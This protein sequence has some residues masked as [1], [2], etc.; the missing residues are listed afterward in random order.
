MKTILLALSGLLIASGLCMAQ[1]APGTMSQNAQVILETQADGLYAA[2]SDIQAGTEIRIT[3]ETNGKAITATA[4]ERL[5]KSY[6]RVVSLSPDAA[7]QLGVSKDDWVKLTIASRPPPIQV[8]T[9]SASAEAAPVPGQPGGGNVTINNYYYIFD[10]DKLPELVNR[11]IDQNRSAASVI[12][13]VQVVPQETEEP[14]KPESGAS[15]LFW[16]PTPSQSQTTEEPKKPG[17]SGTNNRVA[18][19]QTDKIKIIGLPNPL[20]KKYYR[21]QVGAFLNNNMAKAIYQKLA[22]GG[23][24]P[25]IEYVKGRVYRVSVPKVAAADVLTQARRL[26]ALGFM[27]IWVREEK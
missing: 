6:G 22:N 27:E 24:K 2:H 3:N 7:K 14:K 17:N 10:P 4:I 26:G 12:Q 18:N 8:P 21:L 16:E 20:G 23:F 19:V 1:A 9:A 11:T 25:E 13:Q 5:P 15:D